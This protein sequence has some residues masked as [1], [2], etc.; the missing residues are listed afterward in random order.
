MNRW[1][2]SLI[3]LSIDLIRLRPRRY[4]GRVPLLN[5]RD[6]KR[7]RWGTSFFPGRALHEKMIQR[8]IG[9][10]T[11]VSSQNEE[12]PSS[13]GQAGYQ[14]VVNRPLC[15]SIG[16]HGI[17]FVHAFGKSFR[18]AVLDALEGKRAGRLLGEPRCRRPIL[19]CPAPPLCRA[20]PCPDPP[21]VCLGFGFD[22]FGKREKRLL[23][24]RGFGLDRIGP[25]CHGAQ[26]LYGCP[27]KH[28]MVASKMGTAYEAIDQAYNIACLNYVIRLFIILYSISRLSRIPKS[29]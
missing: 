6:Q 29:G 15:S 13:R 9:A 27:W 16:L 12:Q 21:V 4:S 20:P 25:E 26:M 5:R 24:C 18:T 19:P 14:L 28:P 3:W 8:Q 7:D 22:R 10:G 17:S 11:L 1:L 23:G 2:R